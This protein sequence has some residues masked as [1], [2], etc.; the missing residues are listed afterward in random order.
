MR[1]TS[2]VPVPVR[3]ISPALGGPLSVSMGAGEAGFDFVFPFVCLCTP[4]RLCFSQSRI[5][6]IWF[7]MAE[8]TGIKD[9]NFKELLLIS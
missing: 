2:S 4:G 1:L 6:A 3:W 5:L 8:T 9:L 7:I